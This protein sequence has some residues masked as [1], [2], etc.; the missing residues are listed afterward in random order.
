MFIPMIEIEGIAHKQLGLESDI[1][2]VDYGNLRIVDF[3][4]A[5]QNGNKVPKET[6]SI[7]QLNSMNAHELGNKII[8]EEVGD[9][10]TDGIGGF[11]AVSNGNNYLLAA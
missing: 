6:L 2:F 8:G 5:D 7:D 4:C 9:Y 3:A 11:T 1:D 10:S